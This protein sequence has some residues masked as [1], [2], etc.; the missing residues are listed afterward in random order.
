MKHPLPPL[1]SVR[2]FESAARH[3]SFRRA[4]EE[5]GVTP[6][7]VSQ[8]IQLLEEHLGVVLFERR[9]KGLALSSAGEQL[10]PV[11][12]Q[13]LQVLSESFMRLRAPSQVVRF[14][15]A[16][17]LCARWLVPRLGGFFSAYPNLKV[18]IDASLRYVEFMSEPF[19]VAIRYGKDPKGPLRHIPLFPD[20]AV[21]ICLP[22]VAK[23][24]GRDASKLQDQKLLSWATQNHW[25]QWFETNKLHGF[26]NCD[27]VSF[28]LLS[29]AIDAA[30][31]GQGIALTSRR[32]VET[33][34]ALGR[35]ACLPFPPVVTGYGYYVVGRPQTVEEPHVKCFID[36][37][38]A[39]ARKP[40]NAA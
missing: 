38:L 19:D 31:A 28:S 14:S 27:V 35:L 9:A 15:G 7:A 21:A 40:L 8:Q 29:L 26:E 23:R 18:Q 25:P 32:L 13:T 24:I 11:V 6:G 36:W 30:I 17:T 12:S 39:E 20:D 16:P 3:L 4:A 34:L 33:D 22:E 2:V 1:K 37:V 10:A 5:L